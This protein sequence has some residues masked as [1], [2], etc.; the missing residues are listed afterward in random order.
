MD[1]LSLRS[2]FD[3]RRLLLVFATV[4]VISVVDV[5]YLQLSGTRSAL[6]LAVRIVLFT[7]VLYLGLTL[8]DHT[9]GSFDR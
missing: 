2:T 5:Y 1:P 6:D 8:A 9:V 4:V 7:V 3:A